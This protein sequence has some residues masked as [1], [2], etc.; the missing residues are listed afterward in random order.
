MVS[1][2][3]PNFPVP[4]IDQ[5]SKGFRDNFSIIKEEIET[6]QGVIVNGVTGPTGP[7]GGGGG[8]TGPTGPVGGEGP[9]GPTGPSWTDPVGTYH[10]VTGSRSLNTVYTNTNPFPI[11][12]QV[13]MQASA[14]CNTRLYVEDQ[15]VWMQTISNSGYLVTL[16]GLINPGET[17]YTESDGNYAVPT[18][19]LERYSNGGL[20]STANISVSN[21]TTQLT[22]AV[23]SFT[24]QGGLNTTVSS[25]N[26]TVSG[27]NMP[28]VIDRW[29]A[30][31][32]E[33]T[34]TFTVPTGYFSFRIYANIR[35][36]A[37]VTSTGTY[38]RFNNDSGNNYDIGRSFGTGDTP[39]AKQ[40]AGQPG[41]FLCEPP[42]SLVG[43]GQTST[44]IIT[45][46]D[47]LGPF[48]KNA[49]GQYNLD[50]GSALYTFIVSNWWNVADP[51]TSIRFDMIDGNF[52]TGSSI[53]LEMI[54]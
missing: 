25:S 44:G 51:I 48:F 8:T 13:Q 46:V 6:L 5:S 17:Y 38:I 54:P 49:N 32:I 36:D 47:Y 34:H 7:S 37:A 4:G 14:V 22:S 15:V 52:V 24:F 18:V 45:V 21:A 31:G 19:W 20:D 26:I 53:T 35:S 23:S 2:V 12:V 28:V 29:I 39:S 43:A 3:N 10:D 33:T 9:T 11:L 27:N 1:N 50:N 16:Y 42:G 41:G 30:T 40:L